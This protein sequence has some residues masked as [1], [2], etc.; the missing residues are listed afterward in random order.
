MLCLAVCVGFKETYLS[1]H[2]S[3]YDVMATVYFRKHKCKW[4]Q[5]C[6]HSSLQLCMGFM[7]QWFYISYTIQNDHFSNGTSLL[8]L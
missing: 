6:F 4:A 5:K 3:Q 7:I 1:Y 2:L 8:L